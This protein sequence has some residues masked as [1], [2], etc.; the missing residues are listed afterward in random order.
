VYRSS[1][2]GVTWSQLGLF[3]GGGSVTAVT[4]DG[5]VVSGPYGVEE[6]SAPRFTLFPSNEPLEPPPGP[7]V[8]LPKM[9]GGEL[10]WRT[11]DGRLLR[12][13]GSEVLPLA[14]RLYVGDIVPDSDGERFAVTWSDPAS[15]ESRVGIF[16]PDGRAV[17]AFS[18]SDAV[19][20]GEWLNDTLIVGN[21]GV[22]SGLL[23]TQEPGSY[24]NNFV[25]VILDLE[26][27]EAR[28]LAGPFHE[29]PLVGRNY[30]RAVLR[31]PFARV[32][33]TDSC[34][35]V[36]AEPAMSGTVLAC[37]ADGVL[38]QDTGETRDVEG[39]SWHRVVIP[40]GVEGWASEEFLER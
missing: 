1:D 39:A 15:P 17:S 27:G 19:D 2:G 5:V 14:E 40:V 18:L 10:A 6:D 7:T 22:P 11:E 9:V 4:K 16:S 29:P 30:V 31:G 32:V 35:N 28:P 25:P 37:A 8:Y 23:P 21:A 24:M 20:L 26:S 34:L 3:D 13:D 12:S 33:D 36:R 38:L